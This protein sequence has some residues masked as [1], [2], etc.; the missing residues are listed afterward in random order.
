MKTIL[1]FRRLKCGGL[2]NSDKLYRY[3]RKYYTVDGY[4][5]STKDFNELDD[6]IY[7]SGKFLVKETNKYFLWNRHREDN[8][9]VAKD[10]LNILLRENQ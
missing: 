1:I 8:R 3:K 6:Y 7:D 2:G 10:F 5:S 4:L 9:M